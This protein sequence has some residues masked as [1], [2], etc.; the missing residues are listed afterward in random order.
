M[1]RALVKNASNPNPRNLIVNGALDFWQRTTNLNLN[2]SVQYGPD[3]FAME[4]GGA[5]V[6]TRSTDVP[7]ARFNYSALI[8][9]ASAGV[10]NIIQRIEAVNSQILAG[11]T[12]TFSFWAKISTGTGLV[13]AQLYNP[14]SLDSWPTGDIVNTSAIFSQ[15]VSL[16]TTWQ[17]FSITTTLSSTDGTMGLG[18]VVASG[19]L[20]AGVNLYTTGWMLTEGPSAP[21]SFYR[22]ANSIQAELAMCQRYFWS[23]QS[24][25]TSAYGSQSIMALGQAISTTQAQ[26]PFR[27]PVTMRIAPILEGTAGSGGN[28]LIAV[29]SGGL[30]NATN[31][32]LL[33]ESNSQSP[34]AVLVRGTIA[35]AVLTAGHATQ[36]V[37]NGQAQRI[38]FTAE[39]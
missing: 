6:L 25:P 15:N 35:A 21:E 24:D 7:D 4:A 37:K 32:N 39:L 38:Q 27:F 30:A 36:L 22:A 2:T 33:I 34:D 12:V 16:N 23:V 1:A 20:S 14:A 28:F 3:R 29:A 8:T 11:K 18:V 19:S 17:R 5:P 9:R 10:I 13:S 31:A 26:F